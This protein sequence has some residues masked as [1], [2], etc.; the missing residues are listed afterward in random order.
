M[1][2]TSSREPDRAEAPGEGLAS[3]NV[4]QLR[5]RVSGE[6]E[7][8]VLAS[9]AELVSF[10]VVVDRLSSADPRSRVKVDV[11]DCVAWS[12]RLRRQIVGWRPG[13]VV[14]IDGALRRRFY[15][16]GAG[17]ASRTEVEVARG[18]VVRRARP[19]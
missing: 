12:A 10:R 7:T 14:D 16:G 2:M 11:I 9:E 3:L 1:G 18:R 6:P 4:V 15:K 17:T 13:D 8:R 19:G 5:G